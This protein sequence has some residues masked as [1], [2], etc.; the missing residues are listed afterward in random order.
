VDQ[1]RHPQ[2]DELLAS[3][4]EEKVATWFDLGLLLDRLRED[5]PRSAH[6]APADFPTFERDVAAGVGFLTFDF[7]IDG[8]SMEIA[9][10]AEA[11]R[12]ILGNP[13]IHYIAGHFEE[14]LDQVITPADTW[15]TIES[16]R[17]FDEWPSYR[18]F[19]SRKL[20]RGDPRYNELIGRLWSEA[21]SICEK[22][23][24]IVEEND[25][26]LLYL[27]NTN[28]NPGNVG[29]A[30]ATVL[31]SEHLGIPVVNNCHDFYWE[32]GASA[33][34]RAVEG[35]SRGPRDHFFTNSHVGEIFSVIERLYP[36]ESRSWVSACI[37]TSQVDA[38]CERFGHNP[39]NVA[40]IG[41]AIDTQ[42]Y[43]MLDRR[44]TKEAWNQVA[45]ILSAGRAKLPAH[46]VS[47]VLA[48]GR[49]TGETRRPILIAGKKQAN[50]D[51]ANANTILLQATRIISRKRIEL[52]FK[53]IEKFFGNSHFLKTFIDHPEKKLTLLVSGPVALG[54]DRYLERLLREFSK[55]VPHLPAAVRDRVYFAFL[56][57]EFDHR[58]FRTRHP[59]PIGMPELYNIAT[60]A[61]LPSKTEGRSLPL[62]ESAACG[63][64][65]LTCRY[66]PAE[67]FSEVI[68][69]NLAREDRLD[70]TVF[71][72]TH[73]KDSTVE[74]LCERLL[75]TDHSEA[76]RR[77]NRRVV[78]RRFSV[79]IL[80][81]DLGQILEKLYLQMQEPNRWMERASDAMERFAQRVAVESPKLEAL[82]ETRQRE[83]LPGF[84]RMGFMLMLKSLIDP[85]YF[86]IEEQ[87]LRGM[88]FEFAMRLM[89]ETD[90]SRDLD[91]R[92][93]ADFYNTVDSLFLVRK[94]EVPIQ[95]DHSLAYRHRN[96]RRYCYRELTPQE[97]T[98]VIASVHR[99]AFG[100]LT[101]VE[102]VHEASHQV[103]DWF[104]MVARCFG[105]GVPE[106]DDRDILYERLRENVP[107]AIFPGALT[108]HELEVFVLEAV[109]SRLG[110][111]IHDELP[112]KQ[113]RRIEHLAPITIIERRER[114]P[115]GGSA[116]SLEKYL[117]EQ[118]D[119]E[120]KLLHERGVCRVV[121]SEQISVG[122]DFRQLGVEVIEVLDGIRTAGGFI[123]ALCP[124]A[125]V[126][127]DAAILDRFHIGR[128]T[129]PTTANILGIALGASYVEW[130]PAGLRPTL[131]YPTPVQTAKSLSE[132]LH[133]PRFARLRK[134]LGDSKLRTA[135]C[136][137]AISRGS[138]VEDLLQRLVTSKR[139][140]PGRVEAQSLNGV[141]DDGCPW[142]GVIASVPPSQRPLR[143]AILSSNRGNQ[144]VPEFVRRFD[145]SHSSRAQIAWNGGYILN[146][147]L[148]GKLGLPE[149]YIGSPLGLIISHGRLLSPPLFNKP[150]FLV[151]E[152]RT[153][154]IRRVSCEL[155]LT[156][157]A[158]RTTVELGPETRNLENPG[159]DA[160]FYDLFH[161]SATLPGDGRTIVRLV[162]NRI[163]E[164]VDT[165]PGENPPV[166]PVGL[167]ISFPPGGVPSG[168]EAGQA[169]AIKVA[170]LGD[171]ANAVE[172]GPLLLDEGQIAI[173]MEREGWKTRTSIQT[174]AARIDYLDMR[175][176]KIA[177]GL[178]DQGTLVV[179][180]VNGRI[181]ESVGATHVDM[182]EILR[183][184][185]MRSAMGFDP[186]GSATLVVGKEILNI[187]PYNH[188][189]ERNVYSLPPE[190]R[191]VA[192]V[193]VGY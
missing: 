157:R 16:M 99:D 39:A 169:L 75:S 86:R 55:L 162:G 23:G 124:H 101:S 151:G 106:I 161:D 58:E 50:V 2:T 61:V 167:V 189:Y 158:N 160:C 193:V 109:R 121:A 185:G 111:G 49:F 66:D 135:L 59:D 168:W 24:A 119:S 110:L 178:D 166:L 38:L 103:A 3:L 52:N 96:R 56:F 171:I 181:R 30:L 78:E 175:G 159:T 114:L 88:A 71:E 118:A 122:I 174:Q 176:P 62:I 129:D 17:G 98:G 92:D 73:F 4:R 19:F 117:V 145:R 94:G 154:S 148:V 36:W 70:V 5:P 29:V 126:T 12:L 7:G 188:D 45:E 18:D 132:T 186:G 64:L 150:A 165:K 139:S 60:L 89:R 187:S 32:G 28:S 8:V 90:P 131:A 77:H 170:G 34:E 179:L 81:R 100:P 46:S 172:A 123:V 79:E 20:E 44:R 93:C 136:E 63:V 41:T 26:R 57:S 14:F 112:E 182:A 37:N 25:I 72:G 65:I 82:L 141:Y 115:G 143:Y 51:F 156:V 142:S 76:I 152:D 128:A 91:H 85:S 9:K 191:S 13:K 107:V 190:P 130:A 104:S 146:P 69:E 6:H 21:L 173:D 180:A 120:L 80:T 105:G 22:L 43:T 163:M 116:E 33:V 47:D 108:E 192:N 177:I 54:N 1:S 35:T 97:L 147:E 127:T 164:I 184:R 87:R 10:Y 125:A 137:D 53:L 113:A 83:Y 67:V 11:L 74:K 140:K 40:G 144:T 42:R 95:V 102:V 149:G 48:E 27:T 134:R 153:L 155:G 133:S 15:H 138:R 31:V 84:G 183:K 68:G